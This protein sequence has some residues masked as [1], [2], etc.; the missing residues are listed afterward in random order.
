MVGRILLGI[1]ESLYLHDH[2]KQ[3]NYAL[4]FGQTSNYIHSLKQR[5]F[6]CHVLF[7]SSK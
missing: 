6:Y 5:Y 2:I 3:G 4:K 1:P 7:L